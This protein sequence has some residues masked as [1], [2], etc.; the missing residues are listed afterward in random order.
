MTMK[1]L[2]LSQLCRPC[3]PSGFQFE[4]TAELQPK[5]H[6][7]GQPRGTQ[8]IEFGIRVESPGYNIYIMGETGTGRTTA[9][10]RFLEGCANEDPIPSDWAYVHNFSEPH[11]PIALCLPPGR[12]LELRKSMKQLIEHLKDALP[13]AFDT[14]DFREAANAIRFNLDQT[15]TEQL[16]AIQR[17]ASEA[18][19]ALLTTPEGLQIVPTKDGQPLT[20]QDFAKLSDQE[21]EGWRKIAEELEKELQRTMEQVRKL[22]TEAQRAMQA[23]V[24]NVASVVVNASIQ[25]TIEGFKD[26]QETVEYWHSVRNDILDHVALFRPEEEVEESERIPA[27]L[28]FRRYEVNII[29]DHSQS[30]GAPVV[31]EHNPTIPRLLGRVEHESRFGG[32]IMTDFTLIRGGALHAANGGYLLLRASELFTEPGGWDTL[33]RALIGASLRPD[34]PATR[35]GAATRSLDPEP[36]PLDLKVILVGPPQLFYMLHETDDD[37]R[38]I[39]KVMADFDE[40]MPRQAENEI[41]YATFIAARC[42]EE[43]LH[44]FD[45]K[46]I[47]RVIEYGSRLAGSQLKLST[48]FGQIADLVR[49][50]DYWAGQAKRELVTGE[51]VQRA[52]QEQDFRRN[53]LQLKQVERTL[54]GTLLIATEGEG[55]G[56]VNGVA[57]SS[58]GDYS[59]G[60]PTRVTARTYVG[61]EGVIQIDREVELAGPIHNKGVL[62]L[63]GYL[64]GQYADD[65]PLSLSAQITF[66]QIYG[67]IEGDSAS[68]AELFALLSSLAEIPVRQ[69]IAVTGSVNQLGEIQAIGGVTE[70][71]EGWFN[72]CQERKLNG[73]QG[74]LIPQSNTS[75][76]ML[77]EEV[78]KAVEDGLFKVWAVRTVDEALEVLT[79][80]PASKVHASVKDRLKLLAEKHDASGKEDSE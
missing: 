44:H 71:I 32:A 74:M 59:F 29:V 56:Q 52:V 69:A 70:K 36:I 54:D 51:D 62:T 73:Q 15:R 50:A 31:V 75:D 43:G 26:E 49:E 1:P 37:F 16:A 24:R 47:A 45:R 66:E 68:T 34:D 63:I 17:K 53:R 6:I 8:A 80:Q 27:A 41:E 61:K 67:G 79:G 20:P 12:G 40:E 18:H 30:K 65:Q 35:G 77:K 55:I 21:R 10:E 57:L 42:T 28:R 22:E 13:R 5:T 4:T 14:D 78:L 39:F 23:L 48:R 19:A 38:T 58:V 11:K 3:D 72:V 25:A 76:L 7:I 2:S 64:G 46:A 9:I 33:K 60:H